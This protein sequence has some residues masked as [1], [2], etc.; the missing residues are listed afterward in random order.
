MVA[1]IVPMSSVGIVLIFGRR[2]VEGNLPYI[3]LW[4][5][6]RKLWNKLIIIGIAVIISIDWIFVVGCILPVFYLNSVYLWQR[7]IQEYWYS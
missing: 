7:K 1:L 3:K 6:G 4:N 2:V 5:T